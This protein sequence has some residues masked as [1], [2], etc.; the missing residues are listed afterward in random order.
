MPGDRGTTTR[1]INP[2]VPSSRNNVGSQQSDL[3]A[4]PLRN[5]SGGAREFGD[6]R[7]TLR[8]VE[9]GEPGGPSADLPDGSE[10]SVAPGR[11]RFTRRWKITAAVVALVA[12]WAIAAVVVVAV[13]AEHIHHGEAEVQ[14]AR[15]SLS[16]DGILSGAPSQ[17]LHSADSSFSS[18][19][20]SAVLA[21]ALARRCPP[22]GGAPAPLGAGPLGGRRAGRTHRHRHGRAIPVAAPSPPFRRTGPGGGPAAAGLPGGLHP[23]VSLRARSGP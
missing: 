8:P 15:Q 2:T 3:P 10:R 14:S 19:H 1:Q 11:R 18:A 9:N 12:V 6:P 23:P 4:K 13:A 20:A 17:S 5:S 7:C 22:G 21:P 16:A